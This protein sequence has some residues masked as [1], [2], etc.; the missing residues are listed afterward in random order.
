[1]EHTLSTLCAN[2]AKGALLVTSRYPLPGLAPLLAEIPVPALSPSELR[3]LFL[4]LPALRDLDPDERRLLHRTIGGHPRLIE[5]VDALLRGGRANLIHVQT[6][7]RDLTDR[8][9]ID[10]TR[11]AP[12]GQAVDQAMLLGSAD[13]LLEELLDLLSTRQRELLDQVSVCRAPMRLEDL[14]YTLTDDPE[15]ATTT[16][17]S[18]LEADVDRLADLTLLTADPGIGM[19]PW[20]AELLE[21][22]VT[23]LT[24]HHERALAMRWH[25]FSRGTVDYLD[26]LDI[27][28]HFAA[29]Q[30]YDE[31]ADFARQI[32][33]V[34][35]GTL[36]MAAYLAESAPSSLRVNAR[37]H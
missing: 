14:A 27:P 31:L 11:P 20:T 26:L 23:D 22:R 28:R 29:L 24:G 4:R 16:E 18:I 10:L 6:K 7:L 13:I 1:M 30:Q 17:L 9:G 8:E 34:L 5:F 3:R 37:G 36:A 15:H 19:H 35:P 25:R 32:T 21:R 33:E 12:L 2:A